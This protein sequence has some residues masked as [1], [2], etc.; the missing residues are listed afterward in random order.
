[1]RSA[2]LAAVLLAVVPVM[3]AAADTTPTPRSN[4][5]AQTPPM[6]WS[7]WNQFG[8]DINESI[9]VETIDAMVANGMRDVGYVCGRTRTLGHLTLRFRPKYKVTKRAYSWSA[10]SQRRRSR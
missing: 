10:R 4:G 3:G 2:L 9:V 8:D 7:S 6:G 5:L 1:V